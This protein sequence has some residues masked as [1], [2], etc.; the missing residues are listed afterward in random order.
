MGNRAKSLFYLVLFS[1]FHHRTNLIALFFGN[2]AFELKLRKYSEFQNLKFL[3]YLPYKF[4]LR[5]G[6]YK[7]CEGNFILEQSN[8]TF[9]VF[10]GVQLQK[11]NYILRIFK[12]VNLKGPIIQI[13]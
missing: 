10:F 12:F 8:G 5:M 2:F 9:V 6:K 3:G 13:P 1:K 11:Q 7:F 4:R